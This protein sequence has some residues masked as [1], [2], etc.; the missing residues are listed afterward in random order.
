MQNNY[1][2]NIDLSEIISKDL[3]S[4][5]A[6]QIA[7]SIKEASEDI[8]FFTVTNHGIPISKINNLC[9]IPDSKPHNYFSYALQVRGLGRLLQNV[10][11]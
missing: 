1:I 4:D 3:N 11:Q 10:Y 6:K 7:K 9:I 2:P 8:G 5:A